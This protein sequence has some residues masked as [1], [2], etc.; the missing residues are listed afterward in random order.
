MQIAYS[1]HKQN[2]YSMLKNYFKIAFRS[3]ARNKTITMINVLGLVIG[4]SFSCMLYVYVNNELSYD[5]FHS[6][7]ERIFRILTID[8]RLPQNERTY[9]VTAPPL[10]QE[11]VNN[12]AEVEEMVRMYR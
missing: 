1:G 11:L 10:G 8:K 3:L 6:K 2:N 9:A 12:Y 4:I 5:S 7:A